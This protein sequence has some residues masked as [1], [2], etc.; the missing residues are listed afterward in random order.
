MVYWVL[1]LTNISSTL[2]L[3]ETVKNVFFYI[4]DITD[5][6]FH[7]AGT[8]SGYNILTQNKSSLLIIYIYM[9]RQTSSKFGG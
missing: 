7:Y 4:C 1:N 5:L 8:E 6:L 9:S 3:S 2:S